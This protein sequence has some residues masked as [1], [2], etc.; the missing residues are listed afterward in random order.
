LSKNVYLSSCK[1]SLIIVR[2][3]I[4]LSFLDR[5]KKNSK[6][7]FT[8]ILSVEAELFYADRQTERRTDMTKP[9]V[10]SRK[11]FLAPVIIAVSFV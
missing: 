5:L 7:N 10:A 2:F 1:V 8:K 9:T 3:Q 6:S 4:N 11:F